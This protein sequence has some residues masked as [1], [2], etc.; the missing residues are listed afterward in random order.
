MGIQELEAKV[1]SLE[2]KVRKLEDIDQ[3]KELQRIY[4]YY[5]DNRMYDEAIDLFSENTEYFEVSS[6]GVFRGK[7]G[8]RKFL[9]NMKNNSLKKPERARGLSLHMQLQGV[10]HLNPDGKTAKGRW[11]CWMVLNQTFNKEL[12]AI[13]GLGVFEN[14]YIKED[15]KWLFKILRVNIRFMAP[16]EDGWLKTPF[17]AAS[18]QSIADEPATADK[19]YPSGYDIPLHFKHP[20]TGK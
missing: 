2:E 9:T 4:G 8:V 1:K 13:W 16:Y 3:I 17:S 18:G 11:Q 10:V 6:L 7:A 20:I 19:T 15:D 5:L 14:E 12:H